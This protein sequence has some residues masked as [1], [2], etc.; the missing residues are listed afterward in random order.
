MAALRA[1]GVGRLGCGAPS[2]WGGG[3]RLRRSSNV[4]GPPGPC[5][6]DGVRTCARSRGG[7][8]QSH[9]SDV[10]YPHGPPVPGRAREP[11][12][13]RIPTWAHGPVAWQLGSAS[14]WSRGGMWMRV[15]G[16]LM[17]F[18]DQPGSSL[19]KFHLIRGWW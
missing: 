14:L 5:E 8:Q 7:V 2:M 3:T 17:A 10:W 13:P 16:P 15:F 6:G 9:M 19:A 1:H 11:S 18:W 4:E 12:V